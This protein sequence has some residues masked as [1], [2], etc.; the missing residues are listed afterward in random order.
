MRL[1]AKTV[2]QRLGK[3][4]KTGECVGDLENCRDLARARTTGRDKRQMASGCILVDLDG[5]LVDTRKVNYQAYNKVLKMFGRSIDYEYFANQCNGKYY[6]EFLPPVVG[7]DEEVVEE[8]HRRKVEFYQEFLSHAVLNSFLADLLRMFKT[9]AGRKVG[10]V[11]TA[12]RAN[13]NQMLEFFGLDFF[14]VVITGN[15][16]S[17]KKPDPE[18]YLEAM[19]RLNCQRED[20]VIFEDSDEGVEAAKRIGCDYY[21]V[22]GYR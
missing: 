14:D 1:P 5:T 3:G 7:N 20:T 18:G 10:V 6:R 15:D 11:T 4:L 8:I 22:S 17:S 12:S 21:V 13:A 2:S 9:S 19:R 16:V